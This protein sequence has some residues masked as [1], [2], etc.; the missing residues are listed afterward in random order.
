[1]AR[2]RPGG[3]G[4]GLDALFADNSSENNTMLPISEIEPNQDQPRKS[5]SQESL[6]EL[7]D[8]IRD[9]GIACKAIFDCTVPYSEK[10]RFV[11][12]RF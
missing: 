12:S 8:S 1:M 3:L 6:A 11:R 5:F 2:N 9:H 7:A 10:H 4:K